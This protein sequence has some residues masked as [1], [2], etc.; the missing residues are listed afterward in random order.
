MR[1]CFLLSFR[2]L[3]FRFILHFFTFLM[4]KNGMN[5]KEKSR[6]FLRKVLFCNC[7]NAF[8]RKMQKVGG[9]YI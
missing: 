5:C 4:Q 3:S 8:F 2:K 9:E 6:F 7:R 1:C